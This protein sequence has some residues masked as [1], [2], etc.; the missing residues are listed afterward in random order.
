MFTDVVVKAA[1]RGIN[2]VIWGAGSDAITFEN[3]SF[4]NSDRIMALC[5]T[6]DGPTSVI[7]NNCTF[8]GQ[9]LSNFVDNA[10]GV[11]EFNN[12]TFT[13]AANSP[14]YNYIEGM[15]GT[16]I[17]TSCTF[18]YTGISQGNMGVIDYSAINVYSE[19]EYSTTVILDGCTRIG[20]GTRKYGP[21]S[22]LIVR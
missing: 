21:N 20:C 3:C 4:G 13:K 2:Y 18:D 19:S 16:H 6:V 9:I 8:S 22:T 5:G 14:R 15:G 11:A 12:C 7:Y 10:A 1:Y 17:F